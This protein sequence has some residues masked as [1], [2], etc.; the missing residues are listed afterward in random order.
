M[1]KRQPIARRRFLKESAALLGTSSLLTEPGN[2]WPGDSAGGS[3]AALQG[4]QTLSLDGNWQIADSVS[5]DDVPHAF[6]HSGPVPGM[7]NLATPPFPDVDAYLS[8]ENIL[9]KRDFHVQPEEEIAKLVPGPKQKR[10]YLWYQKTF[11][12]PAKREVAIL[13]INKAQ[14]GTAVWLNGKEIGDH[15]SCFTA[16]YFTVT[17]SVNWEGEN[18]LLVRIGAHPEAV[19]S[20]VPTGIDFEKNRWTPGIYDSVAL[21]LCDNPVIETIQ[22]APHLTP[23]EVVVQTKIKNY[24]KAVSFVLTHKVKE[25]KGQHPVTESKPQSISLGAG[26]EKTLTETIPLPGAKLWSPENP[27]L[28]DLDSSVGGDSA[29]T[30]FGVREFR[31]D[32]ATKRAYLNGKVYFMRGSNVTLH[33]FFDDPQCRAL[34]WDEAW[35]RNLLIDVPKRMHW[36]SFR[37][38]IGPVPEKWFDIADEAGLLIQNEYFIWTL[39]QGQEKKYSKEEMI[40]EYKEWMRDHWN[41]P[42]VAIWDA[43]N[44]TVADVFGDEIIPEV[45]SLDLSNRPWENSWNI[46]ND[47]NDPAEC[48]PY[49]F[50][51]EGQPP[52]FK[53]SDLEEMT[54]GETPQYSG[55]LTTA[56]ARILNE[57]GWL[58]LL[59]DGTPTPVS[60]PVYDKLLGPNA[61]GEECLD[62][63]A[64]ILCG[65]TEF[66]R[67]HRNF[68]AVLHFV[69]LSSNYPGVYTADH[70]KDIQN[71]ILDPH[72]EDYMRHAFKPLGVYLNFWQPTLEAGSKRRVFVMMINDEYAEAKGNLVLSLQGEDG[73]K[74]LHSELPFAIP[75][76]GQQTYKFDVVIPDAPGK[77]LLRAA[78][79][80]KG[81]EQDPTVSRRKLSIVKKTS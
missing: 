56:H 45:R 72:F 5:A 9:D 25:W 74:A 71:L 7:A 23:R 65:E 55:V 77:C 26:E 24:G 63:D 52:S 66:W 11:S 76:L 81:G 38:C 10:N 80:R 32:T 27:F 1:N 33:R 47:P 57:Y 53:L 30:R 37:F 17:E 2:S 6:E 43:T 41:H 21:H 16:G 13:K 50:A 70:F 73:K 28:Y 20:F 12:V 69:Y 19:P 35:L 61:T 14:F 67:A 58:W 8:P 31:F 34:P 60:K 51:T 39:G 22:V 42:S 4:R 75:G 18:Q 44:E 3:N 68:A 48:H 46:P 79:Y 54:G 64:Y 78:A 36:N 29:S 62:L 49:L 59:R 40:Q 15:Y